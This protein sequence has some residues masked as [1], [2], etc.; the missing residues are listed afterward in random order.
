MI[1]LASD[2]RGFEL[3]EKIKF[4]LSEWGFEYKDCGAFEYDENDDYPDFVKKA[5]EAVANDPEHSRGIILG[6]SGQGEAMAVN[7]H[8]G[9][10]ASVFYGGSEEIIKLSRE[11][12]NANVLSLAAGFLDEETA[13]NAI[14]LWLETS[15]TGEERHKRRIEK[16]D[17]L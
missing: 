12:N 1:Y 3:K 8:K 5:A 4:W 15:F 17:N 14:K 7:R 11:H 10:R 6:M 2:H 13:K 16:I 9:A